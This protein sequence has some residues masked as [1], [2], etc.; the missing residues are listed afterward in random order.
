VF[1]ATWGLQPIKL[2]L[3][4]V[5]RVILGGMEKKEIKESA[6]PVKVELIKTQKGVEDALHVLLTRTFRE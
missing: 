3:L 5:L 2:D 6:K 1:G 4:H